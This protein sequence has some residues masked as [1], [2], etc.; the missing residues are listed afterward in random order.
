M[1]ISGGWQAE[2]LLDP[3]VDVLQRLPLKA[4]GPRSGIVA[5]ASQRSGGGYCM[6]DYPVHGSW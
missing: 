5:V 2:R 1:P 3:T 6:A 4:I